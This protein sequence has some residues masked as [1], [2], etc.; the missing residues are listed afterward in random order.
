MS[1]FIAAIFSD[2][3]KAKEGARVL[4]DIHTKG[5]IALAGMAVV[6]NDAATGLSVKQVADEGHLGLSAGALIGGLA[7][8]AGGLG[9]AALGG[10]AGAIVGWTA[11]LMAQSDRRK[12]IQ[13]ISREL[14][15][16]SSAVLAEVTE[17][18]NTSLDAQLEAVGG[19]MV[20]E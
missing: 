8:L 1:E 19:V 7:G 4:T 2:E 9:G 18:S 3:A 14:P 17:Y 10:A 12:F 11:D 20:R 15:P 16:G 5:S 13:K 6:V